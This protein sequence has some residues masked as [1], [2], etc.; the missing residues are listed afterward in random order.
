MSTADFDC[1]RSGSFKI[2]FGF[3][4]CFISLFAIG[5]A[6]NR[7]GKQNDSDRHPG[8]S[9]P[10]AFAGISFGRAGFSLRFLLLKAAAESKWEENGIEAMVGST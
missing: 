5:T 6:S 3:R 2:D 8:L 1:S 9:H 10:G 4:L 7:L